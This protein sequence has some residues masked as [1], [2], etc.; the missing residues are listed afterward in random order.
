MF[1]ILSRKPNNFIFLRTIYSEYSNVFI[2]F[3]PNTPKVVITNP[4]E[5]SAPM[6]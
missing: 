2:R 4:N 3:I 5:I 6:M 1:S